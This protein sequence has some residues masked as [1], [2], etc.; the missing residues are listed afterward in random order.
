MAQFVTLSPVQPQPVLLGYSQPT[1]TPVQQQ[2]VVYGT[3]QP[4]IVQVPQASQP[5]PVMYGYAQPSV[6]PSQPQPVMY[7]YA[8]PTV[9][10]VSQPQ[11]VIVGYA[12]PSVHA[13]SATACGGRVCAANCTA[14]SAAA[15]D[16]RIFAAHSNANSAT[17]S[18]VRGSAAHCSSSASGDGGSSCSVLRANGHGHWSCDLQQHSSNESPQ[19][20]H[21]RRAGEGEGSTVDIEKML[22]VTICILF[23]TTLHYWK[24]R[25][26]LTGVTC[27][28]FLTR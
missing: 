26:F 13:I 6:A 20:A 11:P 24:F 27:E 28:E 10:Q 16:V 12:Q 15:C 23:T 25:K 2:T 1:V 17:A 14:S 9:Q 8:Q 3:A 22:T 5:Q 18:H 4:T 19:G 21:K 7:G